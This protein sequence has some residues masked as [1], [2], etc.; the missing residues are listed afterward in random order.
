MWKQIE[1]TSGASASPGGRELLPI[2]WREKQK[3]RLVSKFTQ[4]Q[5]E[6]EKPIHTACWFTGTAPSLPRQRP[7]LP[8]AWSDRHLS[9][10]SPLILCPAFTELWNTYSRISVEIVLQINVLFIIPSPLPVNL[11][12]SPRGKKWST[13]HFSLFL[14][15]SSTS[16]MILKI[17]LSFIYKI[18]VIY[19]LDSA[20]RHK[21]RLWYMEKWEGW[22]LWKRYFHWFLFWL[23]CLHTKLLQSRVWLFATLSAVAHQAPLSMTI[24]S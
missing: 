20:C 17:V 2:S 11:R 9:H 21:L 22:K 5:S 24:Y 18:T 3:S 19:N 14:S 13:W 12:E 10:F 6:E 16:L 1:M 15:N 7:T 8:A 23:M 4:K